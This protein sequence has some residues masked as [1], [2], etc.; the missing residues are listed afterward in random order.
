MQRKFWLHPEMQNLLD[1]QAEAY[2]G[3]TIEEERVSWRAYA[4]KVGRPCPPEIKTTDVSAP[5]AGHPVPVRLYNPG[6]KPDAPCIVYLHGG[7]W[8]K[9]DIE[10]SESLA[11]GLAERSGAVVASV[12]YRLAPENPYPAAFEDTLAVLEWLVEDGRS[13]GIDPSRI[14]FA[15]DSAGGALTAAICLHV[16]DTKGPDIK[17]QLIIYPGMAEIY[18]SASY[19]ECENGY[20]LTTAKYRFYAKQ[21]LGGVDR[22][23]DQRARPLSAS[24]FSGLPPCLV[25]TAQADPIRDDGRRYAASLIMAGNECAYRE[26]RGMIHGFFRA[27]FISKEV[28]A[29]LDVA[30]RFLASHLT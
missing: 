11:W 25:V 21:Y 28:D 18:D 23:G 24:D 13:H 8:A 15:G 16:R 27:R 7:G 2:V 20:G 29:E 14:A 17:A 3:S 30:A 26:V 10:S 12:D 4:A 5:A 22:S 6:A 1:A 9:G 19:T